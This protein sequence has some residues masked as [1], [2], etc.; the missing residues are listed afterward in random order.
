MLLI[1]NLG[2]NTVHD[3]VSENENVIY[4]VTKDDATLGYQA[5]YEL[6]K[7]IKENYTKVGEVAGLDAYE[8]QN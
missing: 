6:I 5:H 4:L 2:A 7:F 1:G 8:K 3:L